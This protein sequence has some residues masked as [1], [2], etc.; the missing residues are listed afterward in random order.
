MKSNKISL[1]HIFTTALLINFFIVFYFHEQKIDYCLL[2]VLQVCSWTIWNFSLDHVFIT[3]IIGKIS[4]FV[5][6]TWFEEKFCLIKTHITIFKIFKLFM[7]LFLWKYNY[8]IW[9]WKL[10][11]FIS[12]GDF[13]VL[14]FISIFLTFIVYWHWLIPLIIDYWI[15][16]MQDFESKPVEDILSNSHLV[17]VNSYYYCFNVHQFNS[18]LDFHIMYIRTIMMRKWKIQ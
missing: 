6:N 9:I 5:C 2:I 12:G 16:E 7:V 13:L 1:N 15:S 10:I 14:L 8:H 3:T 4:G 18:Y 11:H 17:E